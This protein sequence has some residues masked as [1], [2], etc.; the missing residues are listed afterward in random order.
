[1]DEENIAFLVSPGVTKIF[2]LEEL[3]G[4]FCGLIALRRPS[5]AVTTS[6]LRWD[7]SGQSLELGKL[8]STSNSISSYSLP[9]ASDSERRPGESCVTIE[10]SESLLWT[11][12]LRFSW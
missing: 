9:A 5:R 7:L 11:C 6:G 2:P 10:T 8:T 12:E 3:E 4:P 1:M